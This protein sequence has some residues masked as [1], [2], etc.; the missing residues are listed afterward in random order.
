MTT[1]CDVD[2]NHNFE[3]FVTVQDQ[4]GDEVCMDDVEVDVDGYHNVH[5][6]VTV[7]LPEEDD[8]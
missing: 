7:T 5:V 2:V 4:H 3:M 6:T 1:A 8:E